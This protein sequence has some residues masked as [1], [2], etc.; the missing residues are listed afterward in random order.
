MAD[1]FA[2]RLA[3]HA[4]AP[5][6]A[7]MSRDLIETGLGWRWTPRAVARLIRDRTT[8]VAV[9]CCGA[10]MAG[11]GVMQYADDEA[12]LLLFGVRPLHRRTGV[13]SGLLAWLEETAVVAGIEMIF[14][15]ARS[16]NAIARAFYAAHGYRELA[17]VPNYYSS[18]E[19]A[20]RMGKDFAVANASPRFG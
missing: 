5:G 20:V 18:S 9:A 8:N 13:G 7:V 3:V 11:F 17:M 12:R 2:I 14:L 1:S 19:D 10:R 6:I 16:T 4:D 15:E